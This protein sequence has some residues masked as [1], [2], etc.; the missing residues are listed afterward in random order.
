MSASGD[1][2]LSSLRYLFADFLDEEDNTPPVLPS[3]LPVG[4]ETVVSGGIHLLMDYQGA[5]YARLYVERL[6]RFIGRP[7]VEGAIF[8][9]IARL[10]ALRMAYED[11][12]RIAQ[13]KLAE[14]RHSDGR[15][16][17][18]DIHRL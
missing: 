5:T 14:Y 18:T 15:I 4:A 9:E 13:L 11:A 12:I 6:Q 10:M 7:D 17:S 1:G 16:K 3:D 2:V 8:S